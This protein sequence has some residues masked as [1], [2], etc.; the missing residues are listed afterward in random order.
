MAATTHA[1]ETHEIAPSAAPAPVLPRPRSILVGTAFATAA[2]LMFFAALFG[3]YVQQRHD[4]L[5]SGG[6]W[7]PPGTISLVPGGMMMVTMVMS[8]VTMQWAVYA[9]A[10]DDRPRAYLALGLTALFGV[11]VINQTVFLYKQMGLVIHDT[12]PALMIYV[13][14]G[15]H[16]AMLLAAI[17]F[18][19]LMAFRALA[20]QF[21]SRQ[22]DG[23]AAAAL[24]WHATV[25]VYAV[26][27][28]AIYITK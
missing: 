1:P 5:G 16:L 23:V 11:A 4:V 19:A 14:T 9:I 10:R 8:V 22:A 28:Y 26:V 13:I 15:A 7:I 17:V 20:G 25:A 12:V 21:S 27:Y 2:V 3:L 18:V 6:V 24:F